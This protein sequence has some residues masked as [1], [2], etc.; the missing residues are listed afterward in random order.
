MNLKIKRKKMIMK[1]IYVIGLSSIIM[2]SVLLF[3]LFFINKKDKKKPTTP[4][5]KTITLNESTCHISDDDIGK[6]EGIQCNDSVLVTMDFH[7]GYSYTLFNLQTGTSLGRFGKIGQGPE[8]I[9]LGCIGNLVNN[10]YYIYN[11]ADGL[12]A[13]YNTDSLT[14]N[15]N[16]KPIKMTRIKIP[17]GD[18]HFRRVIPLNDS[19]FLGAGINITK[20]Y[21]VFDHQN[22]FISSEVDVYNANNKQ[23]NK[24]QRALSNSGILRKHPTKNKF[25]FALSKSANIDFFDVVNNQ[26]RPIKLVRERDPL[27][28]LQQNSTLVTARPS[29]TCPIGYLDVTVGEK[30]VYALYTEKKITASYNSD[31]IRVFD[32]EGNPIVQYKL[33]NEAFHIAINEKAQKLYAVIRNAEAGYSITS[34]D[35]PVL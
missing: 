21:T 6:I 25:A 3:S 8:E 18:V 32:W 30:Y 31:I 29:L 10:K 2:L 11:F 34:Y 28:N 33:K 12:V 35:I 24:Y 7:T 13:K 1:K 16:T 15:I 20:Q 14:H 22:T 17:F 19:T 5:L 23:F 26:I 9:S 27:L 4:I